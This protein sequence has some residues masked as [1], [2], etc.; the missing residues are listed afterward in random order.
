VVVPVRPGWPRAPPAA[1][2]VG[3]LDQPGQLGGV[4][5]RQAVGERGGEGTGEAA[6]RGRAVDERVVEV[7]EDGARRLSAR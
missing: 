7:E 5:G 4:D 1:G 2:P 6:Q 3:R